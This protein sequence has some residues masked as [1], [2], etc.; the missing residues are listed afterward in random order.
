MQV[1]PGTVIVDSDQRFECVGHVP[2][3]TSNGTLVR[4]P[5][6]R[7]ECVR[8]RKPFDQRVNPSFPR[9]FKGWLR[10][11]KQHRMTIIQAR[12]KQRQRRQERRGMENSRGIRDAR[13]NLIHVGAIDR[14]EL[15]VM[16]REEV[17]ERYR[18]L[19]AKAKM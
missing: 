18:L 11:C 7:A 16:T 14:E 12:N 9:K 5:V 1:Q 4:L 17:L 6:F 2:Y 3:V 8:C 10:T 15:A 19:R 13:A